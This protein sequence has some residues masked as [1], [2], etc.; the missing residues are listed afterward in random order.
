MS[1]WNIR[2]HMPAL[3]WRCAVFVLARV[4]E[5]WGGSG[6]E[7]P[8]ACTRKRCGPVRERPAGEG[9]DGCG[10][11]GLMDLL[12]LLSYTPLPLLSLS[13]GALPLQLLC[14][15]S[16]SIPI[17]LPLL[18]SLSCALLFLCCRWFSPVHALFEVPPS[19]C[20]LTLAPSVSL[21]LSLSLS[22]SLPL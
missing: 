13:R 3:M 16:L 2:A 22:L 6:L 18:P 14:S 17:S 10:L 1:R 5:A 19:S 15:L 4:G 12:Y 8:G 21:P 11:A 7:W 9:R 20:S